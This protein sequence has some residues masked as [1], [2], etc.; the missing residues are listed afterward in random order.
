MYTQHLPGRGFTRVGFGA[1]L[2]II[3]TSETPSLLL[4]NPSRLWE[5]TAIGVKGLAVVLKEVGDQHDWCSC[6]RLASQVPE[7]LD[8]RDADEKSTGKSS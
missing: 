6:V 1:E 8:S 3:S 2:G 7:M 4:I 5:T